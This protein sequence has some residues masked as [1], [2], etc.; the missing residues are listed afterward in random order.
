MEVYMGNDILQRNY[1]LDFFKLL[2][3][4][5]IVF[6]HT[7]LFV[8]A[9]TVLVNYA[10]L[11]AAGWIGVHFFFVVSG[12]LMVAS[13]MRH[14]QNTALPGKQAF[15]FVIRK[16]KS[17]GWWYWVSLAIGFV[18]YIWNLCFSGNIEDVGTEV[19]YA[20]LKNLPEVFG[21]T[22]TGYA[23]MY[24]NPTWYIS[25]MLLVM[26]PAYY[27]LVKNQQLVIYVLSPLTA[28]F[29]LGF[30][31][32]Q[33]N[34]LIPVIDHF[35]NNIPNS[36]IRAACGICFGI[37]AYIIYSKVKSAELTVLSRVLLTICEIAIY[38]LQF[39]AIFIYPGRYNVVF[40]CLL[41]LPVAVAI[42]FS[43][44]TYLSFLF[45]HKVFRFMGTWSLAI[46]LNHAGARRITYMLF[47]G[48]GYTESVII[49]LGL[50]LVMCGI[51]YGI[52][53]LIKLIW[54]KFLRKFFIP[55]KE[56]QPA[57]SD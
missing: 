14:E 5:G 13:F 27:L 49:M 4:L 33:K 19:F 18:L 7:S 22:E 21:I 39:G 20:F 8:T 41:L 43:G 11:E 46:Y 6:C 16:L 53:R 17:I 31:Y 50:T 47:S 36:I 32:H 3:A 24:T 28:L 2:F 34:P 38:M 10:M 45:K 23:P 52:I 48:K 26:L 57:L 40:S 37:V 30:M 42:T 9:D 1:S 55:V 56:E 44:K 29:T 12:M 54:S 15:D 25:A 51:C 35:T